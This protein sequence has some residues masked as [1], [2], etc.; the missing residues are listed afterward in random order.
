METRIFSP[1]LNLVF[2]DNLQ[3]GIFLDFDNIFWRDYCSLFF[4]LLFVRSF[5]CIFSVF[6]SSPPPFFPWSMTGLLRF[7]H[8]GQRLPGSTA[9]RS[10][11]LVLGLEP[12]RERKERRRAVTA[13]GRNNIYL[14]T[15]YA[16]LCFIFVHA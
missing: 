12:E 14:E 2:E 4:F 15:L 10:V 6:C 3:P 9:L 11:W 1:P 5:F 8:L 13:Y 16:H 7:Q